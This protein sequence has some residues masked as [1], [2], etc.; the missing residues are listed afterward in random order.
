MNW[1][2]NIIDEIRWKATEIAWAIQDK[3]ELW[4][5]NK[6]DELF[7]EE[8]EIKPRKKKVKKKSAKKTKKSI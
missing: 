5:I 7:T 2:N 1:L 4:K 8:T 6:S 3:I